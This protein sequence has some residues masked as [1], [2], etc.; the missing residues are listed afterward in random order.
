M[1]NCSCGATPEWSESDRLASLAS[2][3]KGANLVCMSPADWL[4]SVG[5]AARR[6]A[7]DWYASDRLAVGPSSDARPAS[8]KV[9]SPLVRFLGS[10]D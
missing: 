2:H 5:F 9:D 6:M 8:R 1:L 10:L 4:R 7:C 3:R